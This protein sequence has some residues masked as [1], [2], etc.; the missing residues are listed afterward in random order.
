MDGPGP[1]ATRAGRAGCGAARP[2]VPWRVPVLRPLLNFNEWFVHHEDVRRPD[3]EGPRTD[4]P[5]LDEALWANVGR[6]GPA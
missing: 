1:R 6:M 5:D 2:L 4:R 3:G